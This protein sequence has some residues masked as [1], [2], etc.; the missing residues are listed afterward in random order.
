MLS[1]P[2][3]APLTFRVLPRVVAPTASKVEEPEIAPVTCS[4]FPKVVAPTAYNIPDPE[5]LF[6]V[7]LRFLLMVVWPSRTKRNPAK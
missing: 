3:I 5:I 6:K 2:T 7:A 1:A 4:V